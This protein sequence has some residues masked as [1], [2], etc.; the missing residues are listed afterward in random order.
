MKKTT[1][2]IIIDASLSMSSKTEAVKGNI[3]ELLGQIKIDARKDIDEVVTRTIVLDFSGANDTNV[4]VDVADSIRLTDDV[5]AKYKTRGNT[6]LFDAIG[7]GFSMVAEGQDSVFVSILTDGEENAS[8]EFKQSGVKTLIEAKRKLGWVITFLGTDEKS[9]EQARGIGIATG[10]TA[11]YNNSLGGTLTAG[12]FMGQA[13]SSSYK[14]SK[15]LEKGVSMASINTDNLMSEAVED[16]K[17]EEKL[18]AKPKTEDKT[19]K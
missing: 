7:K 4:L 6:A 3:M 16:V 18:K 19:E 9:I 5:S 17:I 2:L 13:R 1:N 10:N 14:K 8:V 12:V 15:S 11:F